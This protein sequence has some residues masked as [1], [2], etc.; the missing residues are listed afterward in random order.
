MIIRIVLLV[1]LALLAI[2]FV[3]A[4][5]RAVIVS[6]PNE[7]RRPSVV[8]ILIGFVTDFLDTLGVGSFATTTAAYKVMNAVPDERIVG[9]MIVGHSV[10]VVVQ[11]FIFLVAVK[12]DPTVLALLIVACV[13]GSWLGA[14]IA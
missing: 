14:G 7:S 3:I 8:Q 6:S 1:I 12:V 10:P 5:R 11:A 4:W 13:L 2:V 9:T